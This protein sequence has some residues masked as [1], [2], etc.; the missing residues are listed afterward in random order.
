MNKDLELIRGD[1]QLNH[2]TSF[3]DSKGRYKSE[4][5][6]PWKCDKNNGFLIPISSKFYI[7][8]DNIPEYSTTL[9]SFKVLTESNFGMTVPRYWNWY[10]EIQLIWSKKSELQWKT[11]YQTYSKS[12]NY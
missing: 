10:L 7:D 1:F 11:L 4:G 5:L 3:I 6:T 2:I 9:E 12:F 8:K